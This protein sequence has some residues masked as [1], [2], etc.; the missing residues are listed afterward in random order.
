M[1]K[2]FKELFEKTCVFF[3]KDAIK[4]KYREV[5]MNKKFVGTLLM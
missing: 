2:K 3:A 5:S 4:I 1:R